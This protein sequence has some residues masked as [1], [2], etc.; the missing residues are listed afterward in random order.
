MRFRKKPVEV[1]AVRFLA[2]PE[3]ISDLKE[4]CGTALGRVLRE[5]P[6]SPAEAEICTLE[7]GSRL[8]V[9]HVATEGDWV[10]R[11]VVGEF[12]PIKP[13]IFEASYEAVV[14]SAPHD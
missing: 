9:R 12:Y 6:S 2:T 14:E 8:T 7:D 10:I 11:G 5:S 13:D 1:E 3:G 4:F